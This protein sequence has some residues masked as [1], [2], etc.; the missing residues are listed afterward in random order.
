MH[1]PAFAIL[2]THF[3][4]D[5]NEGLV[6]HFFL[7]IP[8]WVI[9]QRP[10]MLHLIEF[11]HLSHF[12]VYK[13]CI[14]VTYDSMRYPKLNNYFFFNKVCHNPASSF[15]K[16]YS[17]RPLDKIFCGHKDMYPLKG[18]LT[19]PTKSS[20]QVWKGHGVTML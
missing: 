2:L 7:P 16:W 1:H 12:F 17:L 4:D 3:A 18:G 9:R 13:R 6:C 11:Q 19:S 8:L 15:A 10:M 14:I 20:P 5:L